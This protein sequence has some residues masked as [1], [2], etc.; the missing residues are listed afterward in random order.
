MT[1]T[2]ENAVVYDIETLP[3][4]FTLHM[5]M[6]NNS[7][8]STWE[9]SQYRNDHRELMEWFYWCQQNA[10][11]MIGFNSINFDYP[12]IHDMFTKL[13]GLE[14]IYLKSQ[15][16]IKGDDRF[17]HII[18]ERDRFAPQID[19][20]KIHHFDNKAKTT[21]LKALQINMR[22]PTVV[23]SPVQFGTNLSPEQIERDLIPYVL[24][25]TV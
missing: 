17:G 7:I 25:N 3:N 8:S 6:L 23:D 12:V 24:L 1:F 10:I 15:A 13:S 18:W 22:S 9:I 21:S 2:L 4:C 11:P 20:F 14:G 16:I 5:E 19:L